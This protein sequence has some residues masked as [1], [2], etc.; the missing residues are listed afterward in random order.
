MITRTFRKMIIFH[1]PKL[2]GTK[3]EPSAPTAEAAV[4]ID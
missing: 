1:L 4:V 3:P 2:D